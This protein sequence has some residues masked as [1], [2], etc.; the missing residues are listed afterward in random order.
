MDNKHFMEEVFAQFVAGCLVGKERED[1]DVH[2]KA[3]CESCEEAIRWYR[4]LSSMLQKDRGFEP[5][6]S[7][8]LGVVKAFRRQKSKVMNLVCTVADK[9]FD[10]F[11]DPLPAGVRQL[12]ATERQILYQA[13]EMQL[14][15]KIDKTSNEHERMIIGQLLP[16][17]SAP[18]GNLTLSKVMLREGERIVQSTYTNELGEFILCVV[19]R[20]SYDLEILMA[21][22]RKILVPN[23]PLTIRVDTEKEAPQ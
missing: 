23:V 8:V 22:A 18:P 2:L 15:L 3:G 10:S 20:G 17:H 16:W 19:P 9:L 13:D 7:S 6:E 12:A 1:F 21:N 4:G 11:V 5:P 14:D